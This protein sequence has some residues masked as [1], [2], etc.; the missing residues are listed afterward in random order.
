MVEQ[1]TLTEGEESGAPAV[2]EESEGADADKAAGQNMEQETA[3][4]L[5]RREGHHSLVI[6]V[7]IILPAES[8]LVVL[9][10]DEA[11]VGDGDAMS[12]AGEIAENV[13][14]AAERRLGVDD[15][16][17]TEQGAQEGTEGFLVLQR[18]ERAGESKLVLLKASL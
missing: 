9:E 18:L 16:V 5:L 11:V 15:P 3:Q 4:E 6:S 10:G 7:G 12:V 8:H 14:G 13:M 17:L 1:Q 2:G